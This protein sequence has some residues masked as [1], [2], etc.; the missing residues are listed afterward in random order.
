MILIRNVRQLVYRFRHAEGTRTVASLDCPYL[1]KHT[2][3]AQVARMIDSSTPKLHCHSNSVTCVVGC[4]RFSHCSRCCERSL[5]DPHSAHAEAFVDPVQ[6][7]RSTGYKHTI[8]NQALPWVKY[9]FGGICLRLL[10]VDARQSA[11]SWIQQRLV[12]VVLCRWRSFF[13]NS[14]PGQST[15]LHALV[16]EALS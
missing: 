7:H 9:M 14:S 1:T 4:P 6:T 3:P 12:V 2:L 8:P 16:T 10:L 13:V 15:T 5:L 11:L